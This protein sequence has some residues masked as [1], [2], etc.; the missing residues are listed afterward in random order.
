MKTL[1]IYNSEKV[2]LV[3]DEDFERLSNFNWT[4]KLDKRSRNYLGNLL[5]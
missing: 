1:R 4:L 2:L 3:D 5:L